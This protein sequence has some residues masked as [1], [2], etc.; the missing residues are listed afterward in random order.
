M[1]RSSRS[2]KTTATLSDSLRKQLN[3]CSLAASTAGGFD[4]NLRDSGAAITPVGLGVLASVLPAEAKIVYTPAHITI[5]SQIPVPSDLN[6]DAV[7]DLSISCGS[8]GHGKA[9]DALLLA[10]SVIGYPK[11]TCDFPFASALKRG[12][13][14]GPKKI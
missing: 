14:V 7:A 2:A 8:R 12:T 5:L 3:G 13:C 1:K 11:T 4:K 10:N 6:H 9:I